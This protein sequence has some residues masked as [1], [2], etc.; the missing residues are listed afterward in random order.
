MDN[1]KPKVSLKNIVES[2]V[3]STVM[4]TLGVLFILVL[5]FQAGMIAGFRKASFGR[6]WGDNYAKNFGSPHRGPQMMGGEFGDFGNLPNAH[7]AI[8][9]IIKVELPLIV[10]LDDKDNTEKVVLV[11]D[12]TEIR[13]M[14]D[15]VAKEDLKIDDHIVVIGTPNSSG[16]IEAKLI[17][18]LPIPFEVSVRFN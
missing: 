15:S 14:R 2:K 8:G 6:N 13:K 18:L 5:V 7:G 4:Y 1:N 12:K 16:Q 9:K 17:R 10:V 11:D 3:F